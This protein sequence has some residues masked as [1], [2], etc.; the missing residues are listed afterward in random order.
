[1][2]QYK[3]PIFR[4]TITQTYLVFVFSNGALII[5]LPGKPA[6][7]KLMIGLGTNLPCTVIWLALRYCCTSNC[8]AQNREQ[9]Y[10][11]SQVYFKRT[12]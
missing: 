2:L 3:F 11:G 10:I 6:S 12:K 4:Q 5:F 7:S 8:N 9:V 1:M